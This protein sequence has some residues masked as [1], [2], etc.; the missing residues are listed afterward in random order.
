MKNHTLILS[1]AKVTI[2]DV[3]TIDQVTSLINR[4]LTG[5]EY[6][7]VELD[8]D[9]DYIDNDMKAASE[10]ITYMEFFFETEE[11]IKYEALSIEEVNE[12]ILDAIKKSARIDIEADHKD[13]TLYLHYIS[14][15]N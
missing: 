12:L 7:G 5:I 6:F 4:G 2:P 9:A 13:V 11:A 3:I 10:E 15:P 8:N 14:N 1:T